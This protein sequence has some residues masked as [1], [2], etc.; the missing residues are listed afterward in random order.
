MQNV[1]GPVFDPD[2]I[3][4]ELASKLD[5]KRYWSYLYRGAGRVFTRWRAV[6]KDANQRRAIIVDRIFAENGREK[7]KWSFS[8]LIG[9]WGCDEGINKLELWHRRHRWWM[10]GIPADCV[11]HPSL[12]IP[13]TAKVPKNFRP[14]QAKAGRAT[15]S[16][17][18]R[19]SD[20]EADIEGAADA[21]DHQDSS[22]NDT[23][24]SFEGLDEL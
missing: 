7:L 1:E 4:D 14:N 21:R 15:S 19:E 10:Y 12:L 8:A 13:T 16:T 18:L 2:E 9:R 11:L 3:R 22:G 23:D 20:S 6:E 17:D 5:G 24:T